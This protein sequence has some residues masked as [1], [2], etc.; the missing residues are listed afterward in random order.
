MQLKI[1]SLPEEVIPPPINYILWSVFFARLSL[2]ISTISHVRN[3]PCNYPRL[4]SFQLINFNEFKCVC[5][6]CVCGCACVCGSVYSV[7][8]KYI[9]AN[10]AVTVWV[11]SK[12]FLDLDSFCFQVLLLFLLLKQ[13]FP[14]N[15]LYDFHFPPKMLKCLIKEVQ[16]RILKMSLIMLC[17]N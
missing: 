13:P 12:L 2:G 4:S 8:R 16:Q 10:Q 1:L 7:Q 9:W 14:T 5:C 15:S 11:D 3:Y 6:V 17:C